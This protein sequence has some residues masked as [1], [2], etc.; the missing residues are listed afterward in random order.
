MSTFTFDTSQK[1]IDTS[2][3]QYGKG[4]WRNSLGQ[5]V[6]L[7]NRIRNSNGDYVQLNS[8]GTV[9]KI[10]DAKTTKFT[11]N[12][13][14]KTYASAT[15]IN[16]IKAN[17]IQQTG[18]WRRNTDN[19]LNKS[20]V[21][22]QNPNIYKSS[23]DNKWHYFN[24]TDNPATTIKDRSLNSKQTVQ[25]QQPQQKETPW[26]SRLYNTMSEN[27]DELKNDFKDIGNTLMYGNAFN[28]ATWTHLGGAAGRSVQHLLGGTVGAVVNA[29]LPDDPEI[30]SMVGAVGS[31][32]D[33]AKDAETLRSLGGYLTGHDKNIYLPWDSRNTG[34][35]N[36]DNWGFLGNDQERQDLSDFYNGLTAIVGTKGVKSIG[37]GLSAVKTTAKGAA[38]VARTTKSVGQTLQTLKPLVT[39]A[40]IGKIPYL[41]NIQYG[42]KAARNTRN[43]FM[44]S[45]IN[46]TGF[47][48]FRKWAGSPFAAVWHGSLAT[49]PSAFAFR[50]GPAGSFT[51]SQQLPPEERS[52]DL[53]TL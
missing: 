49:D 44:P 1:Y 34:I 35:S 31:V 11:R 33:V 38:N 37:T 47:T 32:F 43:F 22:T 13:N 10:Y 26:Y 3:K 46:A 27:K 36:A 41:S 24:N 16:N 53:F 30:R 51:M 40:N 23:V 6:K 52:A 20:T 8:D 4:V 5:I 18:S 14:N 12:S 42:V 28:P 21:D 7:K 17:H 39:D 2:G 50:H 9:S 45:N 15:D 19:S 25:Q 48:K 29:V